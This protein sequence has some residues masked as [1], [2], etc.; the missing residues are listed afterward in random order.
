M[1][2]KIMITEVWNLV[3]NFKAT[4]EM[5]NKIFFLLFFPILFSSQI[6]NGSKNKKVTFNYQSN[7]KSS[8]EGGVLGMENKRAYA[9]FVNE[10]LPHDS[11]LFFSKV[12]FETLNFKQKNSKIFLCIYE[13]ISGKPGKII[14]NAKIIVKVPT[15]KTDIIADISKLKIQVPRNG[16][17]IGFEWVLSSDNVIMGETKRHVN[18]YNPVITGLAKGKYELFVLDESWRKAEEA[19]V[20]SL[21]LEVFYA[22]QNH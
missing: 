21:K 12:H 4:L 14:D 11:V 13:N 20:S 22:V 9:I 7:A 15:K 3:I 2:A 8:G 18:P 10:T 17:F 5:K 19:L 16:Y 1:I 6:K